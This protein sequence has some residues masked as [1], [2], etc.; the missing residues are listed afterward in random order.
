MHKQRIA[1]EEA[2]VKKLQEEE[3]E[4][5]RLEEERAEAERLAIEEEKERR[6]KQKQDKVS[7]QKAAGTYMT[8]AEKE[9]ARKAQARLESLVASGMAPVTLSTPAGE[10]KSAGSSLF[11]PQKKPI[12]PKVASESVLTSGSAEVRLPHSPFLPSSPFSGLVRH[13]VV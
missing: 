13:M 1:E 10:D 2:R 11:K 9:R 6:R 5:I 12:K 3:E 4:R 8:K 7:A